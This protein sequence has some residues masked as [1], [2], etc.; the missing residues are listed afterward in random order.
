MTSSTDNSCL[1]TKLSHYMTLSETDRGHLARLEE[2]ED[3]IEPQTD[4]TTEG[5]PLERL[6]VVKTGWLYS[7][8]DMPDGRRQIVQLHHAG[9]MVGF[10]DIAFTRVATTLRSCTPAILCPFP[11]SALSEIFATAPRL[12]ALIFAIAARD[13]IVL[14]D[15]LRATG[16]MTATER[17]ANLH[18]SLLTRLRITNSRMTDTFN[19]PLS[20]REIGDV[21]G[22][23][24][25]S[26]SKSTTQLE[27]DGLIARH[28]RQVQIL[29]EERLAQLVSFDYRFDNIDTSWFPAY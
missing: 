1:V 8:L 13:Q 22:L 9:D 26:V 14:T 16:R 10:P 28:G 3:E 19:L 15:M 7:Y 21:L 25:V 27:Q 29:D 20:Q 4:C 2:A 12:T 6:Y 5:D 17:V 24:N 23:T 18:L 11:K